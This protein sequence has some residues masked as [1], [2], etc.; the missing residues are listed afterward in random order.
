MNQILL[1]GRY[2]ISNPAELPDLGTIENGAVAI[3]GEKVSDI[4]LYGD[5]KRRYPE[6]HEIG[7]DD[8]VV[9]PG[10]VNAHHHG[11]GLTTIQL[12]MLDESFEPQLLGFWGQKPLDVYLD[13]MYANI[14]LIRSGVTTVIHSGYSRDWA[15]TEGESRV[16]LRAYDDSGMRV[17]FAIG[18]E[19]S[20]T[21]VYQNNDS[22][23]ASLPPTL[24]ERVKE[25]LNHLGPSDGYDFFQ[26]VCR[27]HEEYVDHPRIKILL[28]PTGPEWCSSALLTRIKE[29]AETRD[30]GIHM[31]CLESPLQR[32]FSYKQHGKNSVSHLDDLG[33]LGPRTSLAH[34]TWIDDEEIRRCADTGTTVC[35][36]ASSNLRFR[37]GIAPVAR[38]VENGVNVAIGMDGNT[39]GSDDDM[40]REMRLVSCLHGLPR[41]TGK[42]WD[43]ES[44]DMLRMATVNGARP[45][46]FDHGIGALTPGCHADAVLVD[47]RRM[48]APYLDPRISPTDAILYLARSAH[49]DTVVIGGEPVL[50]NG[51]MVKID[52][53]EVMRELADIAQADPPAHMQSFFDVLHELRPHVLRFYENWSDFEPR[54]PDYIVN[55]ASGT[56]A[57]SRARAD[58]ESMK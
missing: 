38:M 40:F 4:G 41:S 28:G 34:C 56:A 24:N 22:F 3:E 26:L 33:L 16:I 13:T 51:K 43:P 21:F 50:L 6:A 32:D 57:A 53:N 39:L 1:R 52:E 36:N 19:D 14:R 54:S 8:H 42:A 37:N 31:H 5:L 55:A 35:H 23:L 45:S 2:V 15:N 9:V 10:L 30:L 27:L 17:A 20:N 25:I 18:T 48:T 29:I 49:V 11:R 7:S 58:S 12:G 47:F 46:T 44:T